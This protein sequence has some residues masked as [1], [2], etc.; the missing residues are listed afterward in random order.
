VKLAAE[1]LFSA[2]WNSMTLKIASNGFDV[3]GV[4]STVD[5]EST[6]EGVYG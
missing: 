3:A 4:F 6:L 2:M 5:A 1:L